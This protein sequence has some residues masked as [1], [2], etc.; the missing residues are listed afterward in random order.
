MIL[1]IFGAL[2]VA[3][4][5]SAVRAVA[6]RGWDREAVGRQLR[7]EELFFA[8]R[9][10]EFISRADIAC[11]MSDSDRPAR[12][13]Y[14]P[15][16]YRLA[17][18]LG[19][20]RVPAE[21]GGLADRCFARWR[22]HNLRAW[23]QQGRLALERVLAGFAADKFVSA[24]DL[25]AALAE[26]QGARWRELREPVLQLEF[27][28]DSGDVGRAADRL[29]A[30][31]DAERQRRNHQACEIN[32]QSYE[33]LFDEM[34][35]RLLTEGQRL[36][37]VVDE[38]AVLVVAGAGMGKTSVVTAKV[39]Y[40]LRSGL[41]K[42]HEILV[43]AYNKSAASELNQ[44][45]AAI[46]GGPAPEVRTFHS[47]GYQIAK[48]R[49]EV[50]PEVSVLAR[51]DN[52]RNWVANRLNRLLDDPRTRQAALGFAT[53]FGGKGLISRF[54]E[55]GDFPTL[56]GWIVRSR[57][58]QSVSDWLHLNGYRAEYEK[59]YAEDLTISYNPD[60][61]LAE[62]VY[63]EHF[64]ID[65]QKNTRPGVDAAD[66]LRH[67]AWKEDVHKANG[68]IM[69][70]TFSFQFQEQTWQ[71]ALSAQLAGL[72]R[73]APDWDPRRGEAA[74]TIGRYVREAAAVCARFLELA[75]NAGMDPLAIPIAPDADSSLR[76]RLSLF[77]PIFERLADE[78]QRELQET[79]SIDYADMCNLA[80]K[81]IDQGDFN[82]RYK[83]ILVDEFQDITR[84]RAEMLAAL[85]RS[86][87]GCRVFAVGDDWQ[88]IYRF[89]GSDLPIM[90]DQFEQWFG[91]AATTKLDVSFRYT[92]SI[93]RVASEFVNANPDQIPKNV[94]ASQPEDPPGI[95][96]VHYRPA[97]RRSRRRSTRAARPSLS[98]E[99]AME[100]VAADIDSDIARRGRT[101]GATVLLLARQGKWAE[102]QQRLQP[103]RATVSFS[104]IHSAKG[105][106][107]DYAVVIGLTSGRDAFPS[108]IADD[109]VLGA[110]R[111]SK[112][113]MPFAEERR[114]FYVALTRAKR[115]AYLLVDED[116]PSPFAVEVLRI[117]QASG[118]TQIMGR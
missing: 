106:E 104:T 24:S 20:A 68:T 9:T 102:Y 12:S 44:R 23:E 28:F 86:S 27:S 1:A 38:D 50:G 60:W 101:S 111:S 67:M 35:G 70:R 73:K 83:Y 90:T 94:E 16:W 79:E 48:Q 98:L 92:P 6:G 108:D 30:G 110:V 36:S 37:A 42:P 115:R 100:V 85:Q 82:S 65:R 66:Y 33:A 40:L 107:A 117:G 87:P 72:P 10:G 57:Q 105:L 118:D 61:T 41:A 43:L 99:R 46:C 45:I 56:Q 91:T 59:R 29:L 8:E 93:A 64:G 49:F 7:S 112:Q 74:E 88:S 3:L 76:D 62:G 17:S 80:I 21:V 18:L 54:D 71:Q 81:E 109:P 14:R 69:L 89:G 53:T 26:P 84:S 5:V 116:D 34:E 114:L 113:E 51:G 2:A 78:Y 75:K 95:V 77:L 11:L 32:L 47:K 19:S 25:R 52:L 96:A 22:R 63:L 103:S 55:P 31:I 97:S 13:Y 15:G 4:S 58:E 39:R